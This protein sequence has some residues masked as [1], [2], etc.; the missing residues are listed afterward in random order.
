MQQ[1]ILRLARERTRAGATS[2]S[3]ENCD[4]SAFGCRRLRS[5]RR[6][7][8]TGWARRRGQ[9]PPPGGRSYAGRPPGIVAYDCFT[10]DIIWR[11][12]LYALFFMELGT[13]RVYLAGVTGNPNAAWVTQ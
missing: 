9:R 11:R 1:L 8:V 7:A 3:K 6:C 13:R 4:T 2:A 5:A 10:V 12:R